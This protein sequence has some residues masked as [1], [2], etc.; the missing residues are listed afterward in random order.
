MVALPDSV[1]VSSS[2][3]LLK[4]VPD[5]VVPPLMVRSA[6]VPLPV[7]VV[8]PRLWMVPPVTVPPAMPSA[9]PLSI[10]IRPAVLSSDV[11]YRDS[12]PPDALIRPWLTKAAL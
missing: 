9:A 7:I 3:T 4:R 2:V 6:K 11:A 1:L 5:S 10:R 8:L 12:V